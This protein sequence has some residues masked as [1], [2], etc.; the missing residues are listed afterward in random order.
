MPSDLSNSALIQMRAKMGILPTE[1]E[2][3]Q[4]DGFGLANMAIHRKI[5]LRRK[6]RNR[7]PHNLLA[8]VVISRATELDADEYDRFPSGIQTLLRRTL[9][10]LDSSN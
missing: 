4:L 2:I 1:A 3:N 9:Q 6:D 10:N 7:I 8:E 5:K